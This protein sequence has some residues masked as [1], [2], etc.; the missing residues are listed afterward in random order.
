MNV[1]DALGNKGA[2]WTVEAEGKTFRFR[3]ISQ[4][5]K[6]AFSTWMSQRV[7]R[8]FL[9]AQ[10]AEGGVYD[11][12][13]A[14][15][16]DRIAMGHYGFHG[17]IAQ[18][19]VQTAEGVFHLTRLVCDVEENDRP[20]RPITEEELVSLLAERGLEVNA[21]M[22]LVFARSFPKV[23]TPPAEKNGEAE[24]DPNPPAAGAP[25][26]PPRS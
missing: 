10:D 21:V 19:V 7:L 8:Q 23:A 14:I 25:G 17:P 24:L 13:V 16:A 9:A 22:K 20:R 1:G 3:V 15:V 26:Q 12:A 4:K 5:V 2:G 11:Q 6:D 18:K